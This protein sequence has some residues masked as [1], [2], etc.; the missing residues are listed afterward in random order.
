MPLKPKQ[1]SQSPLA[2]AK[3]AAA[4]GG[5]KAAAADDEP[6]GAEGAAEGEPSYVYLPPGC[7]L[8]EPTYISL[9]DPMYE[10]DKLP[11]ARK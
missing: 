7:S 6:S 10:V 9:S 1:Q 11:P 3:A 4:G 5:P 8:K 2:G